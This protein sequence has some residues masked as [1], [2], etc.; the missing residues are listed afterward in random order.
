M[1]INPR[2]HPIHRCGGFSFMRVLVSLRL[3][4]LSNRLKGGDQDRLG[5]HTDELADYLTLLEEQQRG[6]PGDLETPSQ[7]G[8]LIH[9]NLGHLG[10]VGQSAGHLFEDGRLHA[11]WPAPRRPEIYKRD[12]V[13]NG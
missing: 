5:L 11:A 12:T 9:I 6:D 2:G 3:K 1:A 13:L 8:V 7:L 10:A 4:G